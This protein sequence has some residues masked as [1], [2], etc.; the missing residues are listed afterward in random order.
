MLLDYECP[1]I[2]R[3]L[4]CFQTI[5]QYIAA[6]KLI[7]TGRVTNQDKMMVLIIRLS[8]LPLIIPMPNMDPTETCV[9]DTGT[10]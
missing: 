5:S 1:L 6:L 10:P 3:N 9:V 7:A 2:I 8:R 4:D